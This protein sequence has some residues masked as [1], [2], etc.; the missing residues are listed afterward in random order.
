MTVI[1][2]CVI[3]FCSFVS[4]L[5]GQPASRPTGQ[6]GKSY[7]G[8]LVVGWSLESSK[9]DDFLQTYTGMHEKTQTNISKLIES[10]NQKTADVS[11][12]LVLHEHVFSSFLFCGN[13]L[14]RASFSFSSFRFPFNAN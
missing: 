14:K 8:W 11:Y 2:V 3:N 12:K 4:S 1:N 9:F 10:E 5:N 13:L 6:S 7:F